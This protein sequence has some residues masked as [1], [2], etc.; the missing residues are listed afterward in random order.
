MSDIFTPE[1]II[2]Y[3]ETRLFGD[4]IDPKDVHK[5]NLFNGYLPS[6]L[7]ELL[8]KENYKPTIVK[9]KNRREAGLS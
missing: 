6:Q 9:Q 2:K 7:N 8:I 5:I 1:Q 3:A 4:N